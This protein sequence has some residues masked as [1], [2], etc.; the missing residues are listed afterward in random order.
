M[1]GCAEQ[2][3]QNVMHYSIRITGLQCI[4]ILVG[5]VLAFSSDVP[6]RNQQTNYNE[7]IVI[8][9]MR[10]ILIAMVVY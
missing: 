3:Y 8:P 7:L 10:A 6:L 1:V 5:I 4:I 9:D 2:N